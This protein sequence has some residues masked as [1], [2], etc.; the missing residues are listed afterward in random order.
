MPIYPELAA[1]I[2]T[3]LPNDMNDIPGTRLRQKALQPVVPSGYGTSGVVTWRD[4]AVASRR[5]SH[6][7]PLRIYRA[8]GVPRP[9]GALLFFH[10][11]AFVFGDLDSEHDRCLYLCAESG[12]DVI[13]VGYRLAPENPCPAPVDD[14]FDALDWV[15]ANVDELDLDSRRIGVSGASAGGCLAAVTALYARDNSSTPLR[16]QLLIYPVIDDDSRQASMELFDASEPWD[17]RRTRMMWSTYFADAPDDVRAR[18]VPARYGDVAGLPLTMIITAD[19]D[20]LRD[21]ALEYGRRLVAAGVSVDFRH[22]PSTFHGF[23]SVAPTARI[24]SVA[25]AEQ[26]GFLRREIGIFGSPANGVG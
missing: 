20:P 5:G 3:P 17:G 12:S 22:F 1:A 23:D 19:E 24:S 4:L 13:S 9:A 8:N 11:G 26:V 21:D 10:G 2:A 18:C 15:V 7:I 25:L 14:A 16:C 6:E